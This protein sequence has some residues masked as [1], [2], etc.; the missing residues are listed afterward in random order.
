[1]AQQQHAADV[2]PDELCPPNKRYDLMDANKKVDLEH[3][4]HTLKEDGSKNR[5]KFML[6]KKE[7]NLTLDDFR[8]IFDLLQATDNNHN[9]FVPP[10]SFS[11]MSYYGKDF[12]IRFI[13]QHL[14]FHIQDL[15]RSSHKDKVGMQ[16]P[17]WMITEEM[18]HTEHYQM[19]KGGVWDRSSSD[20]ITTD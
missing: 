11:N 1:M 17:T 7:L 12:T 10:P 14:R 3:F 13:I 8:T 4:W 18:K 15:Q 19:Y 16:I 6:D 5:L 9:S 20:S 2:H